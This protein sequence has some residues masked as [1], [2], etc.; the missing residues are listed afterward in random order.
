MKRKFVLRLLAGVMAATL[1]VTGVP[2]TALTG[3]GV[4]TVYAGDLSI[5]EKAF[6][7]TIKADV[8]SLSFTADIKYKDVKFAVSA[9]A[10]TANDITDKNIV[11]G[12]VEANDAGTQITVT[13]AGL[14]VNKAYKM[15][16]DLGD[17]SGWTAYVDED[18]PKLHTTKKSLKDQTITLSLD[19]FTFDGTA[20]KPN[21]LLNGVDITSD[22]T[23]YTIAY[24][25]TNSPIDATSA[26]HKTWVSVTAKDVD[27]CD[28]RLNGTD[29][30]P[31]TVTVYYTIN[32]TD[33]S[34][35]GSYLTLESDSVAYED[36][37]N[38]APTYHLYAKD[39]TEIENAEGVFDKF[40]ISY[41]NAS[42][43]STNG[44]KATITLTGAG[45]YTGSLSATYT[46]TQAAAGNFTGT[47]SAEVTPTTLKV[48]VD[49]AVDTT[50][51][52]EYAIS[53]VSAA[54]S[55]F[56][57]FQ[58]SPEFTGLTAGSTYYVAAR[59]KATKNVGASNIVVS[60]SPVTTSIADLSEATVTITSL[61]SDVTKTSSIEYTG[62]PIAAG[63]KVTL[64]GTTL[65]AGQ[66]YD[67]TLVYDQ[68][69]KDDG[70]PDNKHTDVGTVK[71]IVKT[72]SGSKYSG[73]ATTTFTIEQKPLIVKVTALAASGVKSYDGKKTVGLTASFD[74]NT[75][76]AAAKTANGG[77]NTTITGLE[78]NIDSAE[79]GTAN[80][81]S[82]KEDTFK[83]GTD[84]AEKNFKV[85]YVYG[86][87]SGSVDITSLGKV[88]I[89]Q[90]TG[91]QV[92]DTQSD[93][94]T[95]TVAYGK[96]MTLLTTNDVD[97]D[98]EVVS[99]TN[100]AGIA[101]DYT[102]YFTIDLK[103]KTIKCIKATEGTVAFTVRID[104]T[105][106]AKK[107]TNFTVAEN[108][109]KEIT[110]KTERATPVITFT[111]DK[112]T[113]NPDSPALSVLPTESEALVK[114][115]MGIKAQYATNDKAGS[116]AT[117]ADFDASKLTVEY[118][119]SQNKK[120]DAYPKAADFTGTP[121][122]LTVKVYYAGDENI[123]PLAV[124]SAKTLTLTITGAATE[125]PAATAPTIT[126]AETE[127]DETTTV[128]IKAADGATIYY[129]T[130]GS[131]PT[132]AS[133]KYTVAFTIDKTTTV[134]AIAVEDGKND[135]AV[136][137][138]TFT[139]K[140]LSR[141]ELQEKLDQANE[142]LEQA[143]TDKA[144]AEAAQKK[145]EA[146]KAT[147][148]AAQKK[149]EADK[150]TAEA[151]QKKAEADKATAEAAQ[152]KAEAD[153]AAA[154]KAQATAEAAQKAAEAKNTVTTK[155]TVKVDGNTYKVT[156]VAKKTVSFY[157]VKKNATSAYI[158]SSVAINGV[159]YKVTSIAAS[160]FKGD[161]KLTSVTIPA[162]VK[163]IGKNAF[164][165]CS[166][167]KTITINSSKIT[168]IGSKAFSGVSKKAVVKAPSKK[169]KAYKKLLKK[170]K[171][172]GTV[173]KA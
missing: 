104:F 148:E 150:A 130:D 10:A 143:N 23:N 167:L 1:V 173:K 107:S 42:Q 63:V 40:T 132:T 80:L 151:A 95:Y 49:N 29:S 86:G 11:K 114:S 119:D 94:S 30:N 58:D 5:A 171:F 140:E 154:E 124:A 32:P 96:T 17:D 161:K 135:S 87:G 64:N 39:G 68:G 59:V 67:T 4:E 138:A 90:A 82:V 44:T 157:K 53:S 134:K 33:I 71:V 26:T 24:A 66:D 109:Y 108:S 45:N 37:K 3:I 166:K 85:T 100:D 97:A 46:V 102:N 136:V 76:N 88:T 54:A 77:E 78:A 160:A 27:T 99:V 149:A 115:A 43:V 2:G 162:T 125:L 141:E 9:T 75:T 101:A 16:Y 133:T 103:N 38:V 110:V 165:G 55:N 111:G 18:S 153:K 118:Y 128:T 170:A 129:T 73:Q 163:T 123:A 14:E 74:D 106:D 156:S 81:V 22:S 51:K 137:S 52:Y 31:E 105:A 172:T 69:T 19:T 20:K 34:T 61:G 83:L 142:D 152:K 47:V 164:N 139:K 15:Y 155:T 7:S 36:G 6:T 89:N 8:T 41:N 113:G 131:V 168:K 93:S 117:Y 65:V 57:T 146:D 25:D 48:T 121:V 62:S 122:E 112:V 144:T 28:Y 120:L 145:A 56:K 72:K 147:A 91:V 169:V 92:K 70:T 35:N 21:V 98:M 159:T 60:S 79:V 158:V 13:F 50:G 127:F 12:T 84:G 126:A 116:E